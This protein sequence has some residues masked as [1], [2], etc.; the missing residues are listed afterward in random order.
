[1]FFITANTI[2]SDLAN[3][4]QCHVITSYFTG[5]HSLITHARMFFYGVFPSLPPDPIQF[6]DLHCKAANFPITDPRFCFLHIC[7]PVGYCTLAIAVGFLPGIA[8]LFDREE[9]L[10]FANL[11]CGGRG[12][13]SRMACQLIPYSRWEADWMPPTT[14]RKQTQAARREGGREARRAL[15]SCDSPRRGAISNKKKHS[16][17]LSEQRV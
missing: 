6:V 4:V 12:D 17:K 14:D 13:L 8:K 5:L 7:T 9:A 16:S 3:Y 1:M 15:G 2:K 10:E 11:D